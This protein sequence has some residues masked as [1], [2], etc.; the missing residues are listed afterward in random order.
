MQLNTDLHRDE[1][2]KKMTL[3]EFVA[4]IYELIP[5]GNNNDS[6][7]KKYLEILYNKILKDPLV[8]PG[9]KLSSMKNNKKELIKKE[10]DNIMKTTF[11]K[12]TNINNS[13]NIN[14]ITD[15]DN[16]NIKHLIEFS[17]SNFFSIYCKILT[18]SQNNDINNIN[19]NNIFIHV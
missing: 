17:W 2:K 16:D 19:T 1:V 3:D 10:R 9:M 5:G 12:L 15:I 7:D 11:D 8:V 6:I 4:R 14:Y 18:E 13:S